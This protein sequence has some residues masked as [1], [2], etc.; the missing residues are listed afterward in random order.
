MSRCP[1]PLVSEPSTPARTV[2]QRHWW[3]LSR[4]SDITTGS[5]TYAP[6][7]VSGSFCPQIP[8]SKRLTRFIN[9]QVWNYKA[10]PW[11]RQC[12]YL[13]TEILAWRAGDVAWYQSPCLAQTPPWGSIPIAAGKQTK[14]KNSEPGCTNENQRE[15]SLILSSPFGDLMPCCSHCSSADLEHPGKGA[16]CPR[17]VTV[18]SPKGRSKTRPSGSS[19]MPPARSFPLL[20]CSLSMP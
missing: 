1:P 14:G 7:I 6:S 12:T 4:L 3:E 16:F 5:R 18:R 10:H 13:S 20:P 19:P 17:W 15:G 9:S 8:L 11:Q 2:H